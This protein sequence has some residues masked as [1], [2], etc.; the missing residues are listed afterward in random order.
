MKFSKI[1]ITKWGPAAQKAFREQTRVKQRTPR[2]QGKT[3]QRKAVK[4]EKSRLES[5]L[6]LQLRA[7][8]IAFEE[9]FRFDASRRW[10]AD[11]RLSGVPVLVEVHG[12]TWI[13]G[14]HTRGKG[15]EDDRRKMNAAALLGWSVLEFTADQVNSGEALESILRV[16]ALAT[17][18]MNGQLERDE[19][20]AAGM[21]EQARRRRVKAGKQPEA[22]R[23]ED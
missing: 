18:T 5:A 21:A 6:A 17:E 20:E 8:G 1:D 2:G 12:G 11:F 13:Q 19:A 16:V 14:R 7:A 3:G 10:R 4:A 22:E 9:Q 15:F 23:T